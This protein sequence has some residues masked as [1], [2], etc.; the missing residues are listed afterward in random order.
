MHAFAWHALPCNSHAH[1][2]ASFRSTCLPAWDMQGCAAH[3]HC[4]ESTTP[5]H[6]T[7]CLIYRCHTLTGS[8]N[9]SNNKQTTPIHC[10]A[11]QKQ[12]D[13]QESIS[14]VGFSP[15]GREKSYSATEMIHALKSSL[16]QVCVCVRAPMF[17]QVCTQNWYEYVKNGH[18]E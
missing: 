15:N 16:L 1:A 17:T 4:L 9:R 7:H 18:L 8:L 14:M 12:G 11:R 5:T 10:T 6:A 3:T 13:S 2:C